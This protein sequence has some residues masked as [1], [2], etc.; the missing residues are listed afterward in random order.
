[1]R[2]LSCLIRN[3][4]LGLSL[5]ACFLWT[6][7][8]SAEVT[9][10]DA[11]GW[12][13]F[14]DGRVNAYLSFGFGDEFPKATP[15]TDGGPPHEVVSETVKG[16]A[17]QDTDQDNASNK[18]FAMRVRNGFLATILGFGVKRN[19]TPTTTVKGYVAL[20]GHAEAMRRNPE[21][22]NKFDVRQGYMEFDGPW[23]NLLAGRSTGLFGRTS[24]D[25]NFLYGHNWGLGY[26]CGDNQGPTCGHIGTGV[27]FPGFQAG[28]VYT[29]PSLGGLK[30]SVGIYDPVRL[31][32]AW[33]VVP[34]VRPEGQITFEQKL[35]DTSMFKLGVEGLY[36]GVGRLAAD[37][38]GNN[39][40]LKETVWG[41]AGG[42]RIEAGPVRFGAAAF[43]GKG[44][45]QFY[46]LQNS[47]VVVDPNTYEIRTFTG[48]YGQGALVLDKWQFSLGAG[49]V[50]VA[51]LE[52]DKV[53]LGAS[54]LK[55][56][57]GFSLGAYYS[58][59]KNLVLGADYFYFQADWWGAPRSG[60]DAMGATVPI[61]GYLPGEKQVLNYINVGATF[62]W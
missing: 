18:Y 27:M 59:Y 28:F 38:A 47:P 51:Q 11:D 34:M 56:H 19:I 26:P 12:S 40:D 37:A 43:H 24:T 32:G 17:G 20:W 44:L 15:N 60:M 1:M 16:A 23:G 25:I 36:Q 35:G 42:G 29:T 4:V 50:Q 53:D 39:V 9:I 33:P 55:A 5:G 41:V 6:N 21:V 52:S 13:F 49:R 57:T 8:A 14:T 10:A 62:H 58:I 2:I 46:A 48:I 61:A 3:G 7:A 45:G 30:A 22:L 54:K 31:L